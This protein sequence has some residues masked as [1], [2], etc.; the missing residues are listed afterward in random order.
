M[1]CLDILIGS[2]VG[3]EISLVVAH[4]LMMLVK[5]RIPCSQVKMKGE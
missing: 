5:W 2:V 3:S 1:T 4:H